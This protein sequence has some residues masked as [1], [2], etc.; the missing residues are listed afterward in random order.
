MR[1]FIVPAALDELRDAAAFYTASANAELGLAFVAEFERAANA[2]P[3]QP[4]D[5]RSVSRYAPPVF[6]T[7]LPLQHHLSRYGRRNPDYR[8]RAPAKATNLLDRSALGRTRCPLICRRVAPRNQY[9][10]G[11][12]RCGPFFISRIG[13]DDLRIRVWMVRSLH[14]IDK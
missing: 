1:L 10:E 12:Q 2:S 5:W 11:S 7:S 14:G 8:R 6:P 4:Q 13:P 9:Y 3:Y